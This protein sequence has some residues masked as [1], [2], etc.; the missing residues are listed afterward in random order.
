MFDT[1][2]QYPFI[3][4]SACARPRIRDALPEYVVVG[5]LTLRL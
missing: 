1:G 2:I 5:V 3:K 4:M